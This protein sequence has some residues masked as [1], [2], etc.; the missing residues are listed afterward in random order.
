MAATKQVPTSH[1]FSWIA[2]TTGEITF[3]LLSDENDPAGCRGVNTG[4]HS[5]SCMTITDEEYGQTEILQ[6]R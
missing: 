2:H 3:E 6:Y 5:E 4:H 1:N